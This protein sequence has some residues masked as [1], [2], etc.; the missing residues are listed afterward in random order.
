MT[1][2]KHEATDLRQ[3]LSK[4]KGFDAVKEIV[5]EWTGEDEMREIIEAIEKKSAATEKDV[6]FYSCRS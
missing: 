5:G 6:H 3:M 1:V 2:K 4:A